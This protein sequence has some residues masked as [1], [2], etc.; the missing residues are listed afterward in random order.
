MIELVKATKTYHSGGDEVRAVDSVDLRVAAGE[1]VAVVGHSGSGKTTLVSLMGGLTRPTSGTVMVDGRDIWTMSNRELSRLRSDRIGF[2]FQFSSL[3]S[4]INC[5]DNVR[6]P[7]S[8]LGDHKGDAGRAM[9]LL[10]LV[11][12]PEKAG[13]FPSELSGGQQRRV[14]IARALV[15]EP[16]IILAD[17]PTGD[18]DEETEEDVMDLFEEINL[19]GVTIVMVTH[20]SR[21]ASRAGRTLRMENGAVVEEVTRAPRS[22]YPLSS[23]SV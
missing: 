14:A 22:E 9:R 15:N 7:A 19:G 2:C 5:L 20:S 3:I 8:F 18:L 21:L 12:L 6:L 1:F 16:G 23:D 4:T 11:G 13:A 17:E 10:E